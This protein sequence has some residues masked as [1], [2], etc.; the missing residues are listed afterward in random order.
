MPLWFLLL[1][2]LSWPTAKAESG[3]GGICWLRQGREAQ[4]SLILRAGVSWEECCSAG[5]VDTAWSNYTHQGNKISLLGFLGL[6]TC[7]PCKETCD[8][9]DCGPGKRAAPSSCVQGLIRVWWTKPAV[10]TVSSAALPP[11]QFP[12]A[13]TSSSVGTT[14]SLMRLPAIFVRQPASWA[15][16]SA[17]G[18]LGV[19]QS[20]PRL[21]GFWRRWKITPC[22]TPPQVLPGAKKPYLL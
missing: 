13:P 22:E 20:A 11:A 4:C 12:R 15:D 21:L 1:G 19:V 8:G 18:T 6:V 17:C 2:V 14:T 5:N 7:H 9:V 16:P 3:Q 10:P